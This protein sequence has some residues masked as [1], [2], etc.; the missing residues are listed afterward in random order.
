M[1][2]FSDEI[3]VLLIEALNLEDM[4]PDDIDT[5]AAL[6]SEDGLG[7]DSVDALELGLVVQKKY[8]VVLDSKSANLKEIFY[9][10][11]TLADYIEKNRAK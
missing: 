9:S 7:L 6:F 3:K 8:G 11:Q 2:N 10:I 5:H 1:S 4:K